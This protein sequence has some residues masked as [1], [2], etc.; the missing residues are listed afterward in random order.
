MSSTTKLR[1]I[2][3]LWPTSSTAFTS[4]VHGPAAT[5]APTAAVARLRRARECHGVRA[6]CLLRRRRDRRR[7]VG[8]A[9]RHRHRRGPHDPVAEVRGVVD[10]VA[11]RRDARG[12]LG[13]ED[14]AVEEGEPGR[15]TPL[16]SVRGPVQEL[17]VER[18]RRRA[19]A[20]E[21]HPGDRAE[22]DERLGELPV[23]EPDAVA[24]LPPVD[25]DEEDPAVAE[26][27]DRAARRPRAELLRREHLACAED[28][29]PVPDDLRAA[30]D[31]PDHV[32]PR[33]H[34]PELHRH[35]PAGDR[36]RAERLRRGA[37]RH[38]H[39]AARRDRDRA[40]VRPRLDDGRD[41]IDLGRRC[42]EREQDHGGASRE[43]RV[44]SPRTH[45]CTARRRSRPESR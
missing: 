42:R 18:H 2:A 41:E 8:R 7:P 5:A 29:G 40:A 11:V 15:D 16:G 1:V 19:A 39:G 31:R 35:R 28:R 20:V 6:G 10:A 4:N 26:L 33:R 3:E 14:P 45:P 9:Q 44:C 17:A 37:A 32:G 43:R 25:R 24:G 22:P 34:E 38:E 23:R 13:G 27:A 36:F 12:G 30:A 21:R